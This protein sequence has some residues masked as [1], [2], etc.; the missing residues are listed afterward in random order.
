MRGYKAAAG[1]VLSLVFTAAQAQLSGTVAS[2]PAQGPAAA[3]S[4]AK[5]QD[6][7]DRESAGT[8]PADP[9][10]LATDLSPALTQADIR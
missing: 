10:P 4:P 2:G 9:G 6:Q 7:V 5:S 3:Q 1:V 8:A